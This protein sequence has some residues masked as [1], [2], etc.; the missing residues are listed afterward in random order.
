M[1]GLYNAWN[2][3]KKVIEI[4]VVS[5]DN[6]SAGFSKTVTGYPWLALERDSPSKASAGKR[7]RRGVLSIA[8]YETDVETRAPIAA[9]SPDIENSLVEMNERLKRVHVRLFSLALLHVRDLVPIVVFAVDD[10][11]HVLDDINAVLHCE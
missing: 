5:G 2:E 9:S 7:V 6:D 3:N 11:R 8:V 4:V 10:F 1:V